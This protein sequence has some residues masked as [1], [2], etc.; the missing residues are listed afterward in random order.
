MVLTATADA[1]G[2]DQ[3]VVFTL[4]INSDGSWSFDLKDQLDHVDNGLNDEH[5]A[6]R[7]H[8]GGPD[9][10]VVFTLTINSDGSWSFDLKDQLD[11]VDNGLNDENF[12]LRTN[13]GG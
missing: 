12:A 6:L 10:R 1:D 5:F 13:A 3:R 4:T 7:T 2:P 9:Q 8:A 11:H